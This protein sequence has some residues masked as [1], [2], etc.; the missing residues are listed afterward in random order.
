MICLTSLKFIVAHKAVK[1]LV[2]LSGNLFETIQD[3]LNF[4]KPFSPATKLKI[5]IIV[6]CKFLLPNHHEKIMS[7]KKKNP[8]LTIDDTIFIV[9]TLIIG[10]YIS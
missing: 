5:S 2:P 9:V 10:K 4:A 1:L 8:L 6:P 7:S 3:S